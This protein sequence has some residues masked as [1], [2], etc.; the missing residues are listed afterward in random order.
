[1]NYVS[2]R[3]KTF[4]CVCVCGNVS[5]ATI[6][7]YRISYNGVFF[8]HWTILWMVP[9]QSINLNR[10]VSNVFYLFRH[11]FFSF[12][13]QHFL[14]MYP[15]HVN[16]LCL[17]GNKQ[18]ME[19]FYVTS[20]DKTKRKMRRKCFGMSIEFNIFYSSREHFLCYQS[21]ICTRNE[22]DISSRIGYF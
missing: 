6:P 13:F 15:W 18:L 21:L 17:Y 8:A 9:G 7:R 11:I 1:M 20:E 16:V 22:C 3:R 19:H 14:L 10:K 2:W 5:S 12:L 4:N